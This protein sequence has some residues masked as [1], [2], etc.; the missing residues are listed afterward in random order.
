MI[1][2]PPRSTLF[3]S[4][5]LFRSSHSVQGAPV[6]EVRLDEEI[7]PVVTEAAS[8][9]G[10]SEVIQQRR[11]LRHHRQDLDRKSTRLNSSHQI[12]SYAVFSL[13][14]KNNKNHINRHNN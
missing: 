12:I 11:R 3:P 1:R 8:L 7:L 13:K 4:T 6:S 2:R 5:T 14:K 9:L 10:E